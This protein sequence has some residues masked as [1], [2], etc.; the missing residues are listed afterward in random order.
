MI[1]GG[2]N[3]I[4][5]MK[6]VGPLGFAVAAAIVYA[7]KIGPSWLPIVLLF[8]AVLDYFTLDYLQRL[9]NRASRDE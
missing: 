5:I 2:P 6:I 8:V 9:A 4:G 3:I 7:L 1:T